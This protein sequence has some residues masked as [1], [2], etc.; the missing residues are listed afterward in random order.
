MKNNDQSNPLWTSFL[1]LLR[2]LFVIEIG[3][4]LFYSLITTGEMLP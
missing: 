4:Y 3:F 1:D 2:S